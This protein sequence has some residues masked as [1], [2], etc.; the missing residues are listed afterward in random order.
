MSSAVGEVY[1]IGRDYRNVRDILQSLSQ[2]QITADE[3]LTY[4]FEEIHFG[5]KLE[6]TLD[7]FYAQLCFPW[8]QELLEQALAIGR[9][10]ATTL[11]QQIPT[12]R[13]GCY[14]LITIT[15][16]GFL[17]IAKE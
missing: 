15:S 10:V 17:V 7:D 4:C 1:D 6:A 3:V 5:V 2:L 14:N 9:A 12:L 8:E 11:R 13:E 16:T